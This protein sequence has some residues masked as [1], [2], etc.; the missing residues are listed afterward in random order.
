MF[1]TSSRIIEEQSFDYTDNEEQPADDDGKIALENAY[2]NAKSERD[3][4]ELDARRG[5]HLRV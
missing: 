2:Y 4:G 3:A 1:R 5:R